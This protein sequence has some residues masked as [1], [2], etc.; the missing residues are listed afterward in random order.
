M[1]QVKSIEEFDYFLAIRQARGKFIKLKYGL[2]PP[3]KFS[4]TEDNACKP[5]L[6]EENQR[7]LYQAEWKNIDLSFL[8]TRITI[9][10]FVATD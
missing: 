1:L 4:T 9:G 6:S 3:R 7:R 8:K 10:V 2:V 5:L